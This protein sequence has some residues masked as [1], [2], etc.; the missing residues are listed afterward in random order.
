MQAQ[1]Y[2]LLKA[3]KKKQID[4]ILSMLFCRIKPFRD[5]G[6]QKTS[7]SSTHLVNANANTSYH[8]VKPEYSDQD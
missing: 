7:Q 2:E 6:M 4:N 1:D 8:S 5:R 3:M